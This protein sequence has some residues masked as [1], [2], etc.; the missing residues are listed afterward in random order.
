MKYITVVARTRGNAADM[1]PVLTRGIQEF[2]RNIPV[3]QVLTMEEAVAAATSEPRLE[4]LLLAISGAVALILAAVGIYGVMNYA[5]V[6][7]TREIGIRMSLGA[8]RADVMRIVFGRAMIQALAG[9]AVGLGG[10]VLLSEFM[11]RLVFGV[12]PTDPLTYTGVT[13]LLAG[14]A[15]L[16]SGIPARRASKIEPVKAL[17]S[18]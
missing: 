12:K 5:V 4:M 16:A 6:R 8:S 18:E 13:V 11:G 15:L 14:A 17:R 7:R 3:S 9:T 2:D 10:A 1:A